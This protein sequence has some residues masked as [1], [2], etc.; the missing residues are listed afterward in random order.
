MNASH[1]EL[2]AY[3]IYGTFF[4]LI[5]FLWYGGLNVVKH[6]T[7]R[8]ILWRTNALPLNCAPFLDYAAE[9]IFLRKVGGGYIFVHRLLL[10]YF[11]EIEHSQT[12]EKLGV[13]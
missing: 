3:F 11:A 10:E 13:N 4:G 2:L 5:A 1:R 12:E 6:Y 8:F 7:L 9:R